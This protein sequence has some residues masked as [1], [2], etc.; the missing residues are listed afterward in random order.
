MKATKPLK[1]AVLFSG[2]GSNMQALIEA[3]QAP[4]YPAR[5]ITTITNNPGAGGIQRTKE[6]GIPCHVVNHRDYKTRIDFEQALLEVLESSG[7]DL[8]CLAGFMRILSPYFFARWKGRIINIHPSILPRHGGEG[9]YGEHVHASVLRAGDKESGVTVHH[10]TAECDAGPIIHQRFVRVLSNDTVKS[11]SKRV[12]A[13]EHIAYVEAV[14]MLGELDENKN[15][16][17]DMGMSKHTLSHASND[18][19]PQELEQATFMW[20]WFTRMIK[21]NVVGIVVLLLIL[22]VLFV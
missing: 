13:E 4:E 21:Y 12:L 3:C 19:D 16:L 1:L 8:I 14:A 5:I 15:S 22:L 10:V 9:M 7:A 11:L 20:N 18:V 6:F 2:S 17:H